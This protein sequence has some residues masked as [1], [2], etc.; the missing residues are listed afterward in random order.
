[1]EVSTQLLLQLFKINRIC[2]FIPGF[3]YWI[4]L[5][6]NFWQI[7]R[8]RRYLTFSF[9]RNSSKLNPVRLPPQPPKY[10]LFWSLKKTAVYKH[11]LISLVASVAVYYSLYRLPSFI[12]I[13]LH[14]EL[15]NY[16]NDASTI[17]TE[18]TFKCIQVFKMR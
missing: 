17:E 11:D 13:I 8:E 10:K 16:E 3:L 6:S 14:T 12:L 5:F 4:L 2:S 15:H 7:Q 9:S 1:M 18:P